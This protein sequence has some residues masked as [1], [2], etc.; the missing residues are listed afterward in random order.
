[1]CCL[2]LDV[3]SKMLV[4]NPI[5]AGGSIILS[6]SIGMFTWSLGSIH[7]AII[8]IFKKDMYQV[9]DWDKGRLRL[10][11]SSSAFNI[12]KC[13]FGGFGVATWAMPFWKLDEIYGSLFSFRKCQMMKTVKKILL[14]QLSRTQSQ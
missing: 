1:M 10:K 13:N 8:Q 2:I 9:Q 6:K 7:F 4:L 11:K 3:G 14:K 12:E 5:R